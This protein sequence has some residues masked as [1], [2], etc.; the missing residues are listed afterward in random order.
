MCQ[1]VLGVLLLLLSL[2]VNIY[3]PVAQDAPLVT[4]WA[5]E[6]NPDN[7]LPEYPRPTMVRENWLNLNGL[8]DYALTSDDR[9]PPE[10]WDR[11][12]LVPFAVESFLSGV[13]RRADSQTLWYHRTFE[14]PSQW[15]GNHVL[16]HFGAVD[17]A[18]TVWVNGVE[19]GAHEGG[20][21]AFSF[22]IT[23]NLVEG[24]N[25]LLV[26]VTDP[27][28][29][30]TQPRGK[31]VKWPGGI[32]YTPVTGIWQTVWLEPVPELSIDSLRLTPDIDAGT[33]TVETALTG[34]ADGFTVRADAFFDGS[35]I[36]SV[37]GP[38]GEAAVITLPEVRLWSPDSPALYDLT[39]SLV[40]NGST[41]DTVNSYFGMRK[42]SVEPDA[43][44]TLRLF[45]NNQPLFQFGLLDQGYF[46][47]GL[48]T[49]PTDEALRNDIEVTRQLGFNLIR[50]HVKV[51]PE[52]WYY[53]ADRLGVLVWQDMPSGDRLMDYGAGEMERSPESAAQF[54]LE[55]SE[56]IMGH[57][58]HPSIVM[59]VLFNEGW[60][61]FNTARL[62]DWIHTLDGT[63]LVNSVSGWT[64]MGVGD[65]LDI[66]RY[67]GPDA[68]LLSPDRAAVLG[69]FGGLGLPLE[70]HTW[71]DTANWGYESYTS[72]ADLTGAYRTLITSLRTLIFTR[73]LAAAVYT[74]TTDV[75][76]EVNGMM[77]Y[78]RALIKMDAE[79]LAAINAQVFEPT[80][81]PVTLIPAADSTPTEWH[82]TMARP[83]TDWT[84][85]EF[86]DSAWQT[87]LG[88][89]GSG[90]IPFGTVN[91]VWDTQGIWLRHTFT[92]EN[93]ED[94]SLYVRV[95]HIEGAVVFLNGTEVATLE[96]SSDHYFTQFLPED[97]AELLREGANTLSVFCFS[98]GVNTLLAPYNF[99]RFIDAGLYA[100][101]PAS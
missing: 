72:V 37:D 97:A 1:S 92:L 83:A 3:S 11:Q 67:P 55:L 53:W 22:D 39:V 93:V 50:K 101:P 84:S 29:T 74:Q 32:W 43:S 19:V 21:D 35:Q 89:F 86:D 52:R 95:H 41:V 49:A 14:I 82:Y 15:A 71:V 8:W 10:T 64:D 68:P 78:D 57:Y 56:L 88:G 6:V 94:V 98:S 25:T 27:T 34:A 42:I 44:G 20:Y 76:S 4:R 79:T 63:R 38:A 40:K 9:L 46:P 28:G 81:P 23:G 60:G 33:L 30:G 2:L 99:S 54:E 75:E 12:I 80:A 85:V 61:Q 59:W 58:N 87:G 47:D 17:W 51:E 36:A 18:A 66:H 7:V 73:G 48:Y 70:G 65:V 5:A 96:G 62:T 100:V 69:E 13:Q 24:D 90:E 77:T 31:Q 16:L 26:R 45:L 91:T